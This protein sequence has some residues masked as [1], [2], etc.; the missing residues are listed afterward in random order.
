[1]TNKI[2]FDERPMASL[3]QASNWR[4]K[5]IAN[6]LFIT[7]FMVFLIV[8]IGGITRLTE[9]GLSITQWNVVTGILPPLTEA[10]WHA[11]FALYQKT[12][13]FQTVNAHMDLAAFKTIFFWEYFHRL[14]A[15]SIGMV[16]ALP[17]IYFWVRKMIPQ[18]YHLRLLALLALGGLQGAIG[19]WMVSSG[20]VGRTDVS[21]FRLAVHLLT[22]LFI[23]SGL[24][25]T[26]LDLKN[27]SRM[28]RARPAHLTIFGLLVISILFFQLLYGAWLAGL[29]AGYVASDWPLM[30]GAIYP[31]GIDWR[32][33]AL[34]AFANDPF[35][36][37]FLHRWWAWITAIA[38]LMLAY[39]VKFVHRGAALLV[40]LCLAI[41]IPL[42]IATVMSGMN[43]ILA[44]M[45]QGVGAMLVAV[46]VYAL[47]KYGS[48]PSS[49]MI[50]W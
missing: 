44:V 29:N 24:I 5:T 9:S 37:H 6:W 13:E 4:P 14:I 28:R 47:H 42:G 10:Q 26:A 11:E 49:A 19:W 17:L 45:H 3:G 25:W 18:G 46:T 41:Q 33:G 32:D 12:T 30:Q 15:R 1:M 38:L 7:A 36:V 39:R 20:L 21:H 23:M 27:L 2:F 34:A 50:R 8:I 35:L 31:D 22:A 43:I 16:F 40:I 48:A